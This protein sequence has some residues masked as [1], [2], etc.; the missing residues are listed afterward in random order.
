M[1]DD[2]DQ[3]APLLKPSLNFHRSHMDQNALK[4]AAAK[5]ALDYVE[6]NA[7]IGVGTGSTVN[8]FATLSLFAY[9]LAS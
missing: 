7:I 2:L 9:S 8:F 5:L 4:L 1:L 6:D 3:L